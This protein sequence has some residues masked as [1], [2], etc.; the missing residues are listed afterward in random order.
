MFKFVFVESA[1]GNFNHSSHLILFFVSHSY[2]SFA[3]PPIVHLVEV[4]S[5]TIE[6]INDIFGANYY[7]SDG[8]YYFSDFDFE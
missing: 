8:N 2:L 4:D 3:R 7:F 6:E 5:I 1:G